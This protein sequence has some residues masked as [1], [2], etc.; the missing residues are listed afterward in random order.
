MPEKNPHE[1]VTLEDLLNL[2]RAERPPDEFWAN[3]Q[4]EFHVRQRQAA[5]EPKRWWFV[6]PR[7]FAG[8]SRYQMPMGAAAV[9]AVTFLSFREY[10]EPGFEVA[11]SAPVTSSAIVEPV[12]TS[13]DE[14]FEAMTDVAA[15][16]EIAE[17]A[18]VTSPGNVD[19]EVPLTSVEGS[20][21]E[22][23]EFGFLNTEPSPSARSIAANLVAA[24]VDH[25]D[26]GRILGEPQLNLTTNAVSAEPLANMAIPQDSGRQ[27]LF[28]Y[29]G[30]ADTLGSGAT[31]DAGPDMPVLIASRINEAELYESVSRLSAGGDRLTL[32]F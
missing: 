17:S 10:R 7:V 20:S 8:L 1:K 14:A 25:A 26:I 32:K 2:K 27:R 3:F 31:Q 4:Q 18:V 12:A 21:S 22:A 6:L 16:I 23:S 9:L 29:H 30:G 28:A 24:Q 5:V 11:Y 15:S 19:D 13:L